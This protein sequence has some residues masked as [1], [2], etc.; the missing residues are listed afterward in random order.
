MIRILRKNVFFCFNDYNKQ[1]VVSS[2][3]G[4]QSSDGLYEQY[5]GKYYNRP[6][7]QLKSIYTNIKNNEDYHRFIQ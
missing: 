2:K 7:E 5:S 6:L 1:Y 4:G 3:I